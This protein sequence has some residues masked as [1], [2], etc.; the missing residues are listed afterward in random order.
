MVPQLMEDEQSIRDNYEHSRAGQ[1]QMVPILQKYGLEEAV[2]SK[3]HMKKYAELLRMCARNG[4]KTAFPH[5]IVEFGDNA[6]H[7]TADNKA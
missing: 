6:E 7:K 4:I 1:T 5:T 3:A 2:P